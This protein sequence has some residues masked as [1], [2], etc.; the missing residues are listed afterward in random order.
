MYLC[1]YYIFLGT[2]MGFSNSQLLR[3]L[4]LQSFSNSKDNLSDGTVVDYSTMLV[5]L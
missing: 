3:N 4:K 5:S 2:G 1:M